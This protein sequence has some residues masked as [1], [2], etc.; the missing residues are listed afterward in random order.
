MVEVA[1]EFLVQV[2][3]SSACVSPQAGRAEDGPD[4]G[5][6]EGTAGANHWDGSQGDLSGD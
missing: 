6:G 1:P 3:A 5:R 4:Q 2:K